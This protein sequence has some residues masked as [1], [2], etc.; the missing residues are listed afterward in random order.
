VQS[1]TARIGKFKK[2]LAPL[3]IF[4]E[5]RRLATRFTQGFHS[6]DRMSSRHGSVA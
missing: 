6:F 5:M 4:I 3:Q 2:N 1:L